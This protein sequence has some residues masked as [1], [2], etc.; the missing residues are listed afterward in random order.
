M[1]NSAYM[2]LNLMKERS[3]DYGRLMSESE[4][5]LALSESSL[6]HEGVYYMVIIQ[7]SVAVIVCISVY[8]WAKSPSTE[9]CLFLPS[10]DRSLCHRANR[11][12]GE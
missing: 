11:L 1:Y 6:S 9:N 12:N 10:L 5:V 2:E 8:T 7:E 3:V 4:Y